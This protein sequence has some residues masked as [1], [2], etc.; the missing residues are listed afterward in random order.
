[1]D[2]GEWISMGISRGWCSPTYCT[3]HDGPPL[4][5]EEDAEFVD[6]ADP[7]VHAVRLYEQ[8]S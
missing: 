6:G 4:S 1:M 8:E 7:C 5:E 3:T 2:Q